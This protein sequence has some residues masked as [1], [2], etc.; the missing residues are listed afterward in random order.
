MSTN[1]TRK[2]RRNRNR[3]CRGNR[4]KTGEMLTEKC[5]ICHDKV[6]VEQLECFGKLRAR[7][8]STGDLGRDKR[9]IYVC[10]RDRYIPRKDIYTPA[11]YKSCKTTYE[12]RRLPRN[13][14]SVAKCYVD[15]LNTFM[16]LKKLLASRPEYASMI[17]KNNPKIIDIWDKK[18]KQKKEIAIHPQIFRDHY[19]RRTAIDR[20]TREQITWWGTPFGFDH[21]SSKF[22]DPKKFNTRNMIEVME[23]L[24]K[25]KKIIDKLMRYSVPSCGTDKERFYYLKTLVYFNLYHKLPDGNEEIIK[26]YQKNVH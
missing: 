22:K 9:S 21:T 17:K 24:Y 19:R 2:Q 8:P 10:R 15:A 25:T 26:K 4:R 1:Y 14:F 7:D 16:K 6:K 20:E 18:K 11:Y 23:S 12:G 13:K 3:G 5:Y